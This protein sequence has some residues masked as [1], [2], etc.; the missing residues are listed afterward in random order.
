MRSHLGPPIAGI[1]TVELEKLLIPILME[2]MIYWKQYVDD[3]I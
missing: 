1:F 2:Q 3:I